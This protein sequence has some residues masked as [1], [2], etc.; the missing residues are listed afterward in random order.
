[1]AEFICACKRPIIC[2]FFHT[3]RGSAI[4][5]AFVHGHIRPDTSVPNTEDMHAQTCTSTHKGTRKQA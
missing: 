2:I 1:M 3:E 4:A 5:H